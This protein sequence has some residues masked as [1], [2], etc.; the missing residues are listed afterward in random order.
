MYRCNCKNTCRCCCRYFCSYSVLGGGNTVNVV[1]VIWDEFVKD[2]V[3][4]SIASLLTKVISISR[5]LSVEMFPIPSGMLLMV[6]FCFWN[7]LP[8]LGAAFQ[9]LNVESFPE[10]MML[11]VFL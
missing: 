3:I 11:S 4:F 5:S 7:H 8:L 1:L 9:T 10:E 2:A 6:I